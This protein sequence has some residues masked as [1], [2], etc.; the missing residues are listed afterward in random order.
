MVQLQ[1]IMQVVADQVEVQVHRLQ[2]LQAVLVDKA[3]V[4]L[5]V[6]FQDQVIML[7]LIQVEVVVLL[8]LD[9]VNLAQQAVL[10][11]KE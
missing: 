4:V 2:I 7:K 1:F 10:A 6:I 3:A 11:V 9:Q 5:E 8:L